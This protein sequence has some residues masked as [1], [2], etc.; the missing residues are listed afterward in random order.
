M[1]KPYPPEVRKQARKR[2]VVDGLSCRE[3]AK[4]MGISPPTIWKW[5]REGSWAE[6][7]DFQG[8]SRAQ[9]NRQLERLAAG[10]ITESK[11]RKIAMLSKALARIDRAEN[12]KAKRDAAKPKSVAKVLGDIADRLAKY[13]SEHFR[14]Y[15]REFTKDD[16]RFRCI[17]KARQVGMSWLMAY[18][19]LKG[20]LTRDVD[21]NLVS[22]SLYQ[23]E[24]TIR[25]AREH[26]AALGIAEQGKGGKQ[27]IALPNGR[28]LR[29]LP[30]N[31][32]TSQGWPG[33][34][35]FDEMA[36]YRRGKDVW[37]AIAPS[38]TAVQGRI[39]VLSTP[40]EAGPHNWFWTIQTNDGGQFPLFSRHTIDIDRALREGLEI[41][42][43]ELRGLF[44]ADT[45]DRLYRCRYFTDEDSFF[46][47]AELN[48]CR[49]ECLEK[50]MGTDRRAGWDMAKTRDASELVGVEVL[51]DQVFTRGVETWRRVN[52]R[53]QR[54]R[55]VGALKRWRAHSIHVDATGVGVAVRDFVSPEIPAH[56]GQHWHT[57]DQAF[58]AN[59]AQNLKKL[60][61]EARI[62]IPHDDR[63]LISQFLNIKRQA[64]DKG[65]S[66]DIGRNA[67][68]HGDRFW[69]LAL[70][71]HGIEF[72]NGVID[73]EVW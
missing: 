44:D 33:D 28:I 46:T 2:F 22:T 52:Y 38:V 18:E 65:I 6:E 57:F 32:A 29:T 49:G 36:W 37:E 7:R 20:A 54:D 51:H 45:W 69:A 55:V 11:A 10:N 24:N 15:Q 58:K 47:L 4:E 59:I 42:V 60:V 41:D 70:A 34:V 19:M 25:Y 50:W 1:G 72:G 40:Y 26:M 71:C 31:Q 62:V 23:T 8:D 30:A 56:I 43:E 64:K 67:S 73:V 39:T 61:E 68:G 5:Y 17:L 27:E 21:Q 16:S 9:I 3:I 66:Y 35:V 14:P 12:A 13:E 53:D 48:A 63:V